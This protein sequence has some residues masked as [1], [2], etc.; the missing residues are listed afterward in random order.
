MLIDN[1]IITQKGIL[2]RDPELASTKSGKSAL[3]VDIAVY[4]GKDNSEQP[5]TEW[6]RWR[7]YGALADRIAKA[8]K[9]DTL[10]LFGR[11]R[12]E[13]YTDQRGEKKW[14]SY[15]LADG[16]EIIPKQR[17]T[18]GIIPQTGNTTQPE[19]TAS[20]IYNEELPF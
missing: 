9:G 6:F 3:T 10:R 15:M 20:D 12:N 17:T 4:Q 1:N 8:H 18:D 19:E 13:T 16:G 11:A 2:G 14:S 5:I 7:M